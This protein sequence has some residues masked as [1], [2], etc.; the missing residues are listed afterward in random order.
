MEGGGGG[1]TDR[2]CVGSGGPIISTRHGYGGAKWVRWGE[3]VH[4]SFLFIYFIHLIIFTQG[5]F[6]RKAWSSKALRRC[7]EFICMSLGNQWS[8]D[9][10]FYFPIR[11]GKGKWCPLCKF[12]GFHSNQPETKNVIWLTFPHLLQ[13]T[14][15]M[16]LTWMQHKLASELVSLEITDTLTFA[17]NKVSA[18]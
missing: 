7:I 10:Y 1:E 17:A 4:W 15:C 14:P 5:S 11:T 8:G 3:A 6:S 18:T 13:L 9:H 12:L 2:A 16:S